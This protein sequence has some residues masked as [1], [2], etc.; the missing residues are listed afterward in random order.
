MEV[1]I[2]PPERGPEVNLSRYLVCLSVD[3]HPK[4]K[5]GLQRG[6]SHDVG[7]QR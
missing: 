6:C 3:G 1:A 7:G 4:T 5:S 2:V